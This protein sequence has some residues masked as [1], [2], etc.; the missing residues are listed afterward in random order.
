MRSDSLFL[1]PDREVTRAE[2]DSVLG[3]QREVFAPGKTIF[4]GPGITLETNA[5]LVL[6][7]ERNL[8]VVLGDSASGPAPATGGLGIFTTGTSGTPKLVWQDWAR[9]RAPGLCVP[10]RLRKSRW[11]VGY[12]PGSFAGLQVFYSAV[13][14]EGSLV[15]L[16]KD[17]EAA[18]R[19]I[20][21]T[22][23]EILSS[24]P[25]YWKLLI[26]S[27]PKN[28]PKPKLKQ[29]TL[30]GEAVH[31]D[32]LDA[33][34]ETFAPEKTTHIY[35]SSEV[36]T[37][38]VV[39]DGREGFPS[40]FLER[41]GDV[42]LRVRDGVL[43]VRSVR[44]MLGRGEIGDI[45]GQWFRTPDRVELRGDRAY[46]IGREDTVINLGGIKIVPEEIEAVINGLDGVEDSNVF[47][48]KSPITG[49][50]VVAEIVLKT[51]HSAAVP[52]LRARLAEK[53]A[54]DRIP[55]MIRV[56]DKLKM[57]ENGKKSK[58]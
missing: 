28:L 30:G 55:Q 25:S 7:P 50:V 1:F 14:S 6:G 56:V 19:R 31:Q 5:L 8:T 40:S 21:E 3:Q 52:E 20:S 39:Q 17:I 22:G 12:N 42:E 54:H 35:A 11:A 49:S 34:R 41:K 36:G 2:F 45:A 10:E 57:N 44:A 38:I 13:E 9:L 47:A 37:A 23:V 26:R 29:A 46:F 27:W 16:P 58:Q 15:Y 33:I 32:V 18:C 51:G 43:E 24:T 48:K 4:A 53:L